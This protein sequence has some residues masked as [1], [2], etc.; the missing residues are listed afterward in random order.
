MVPS[1][2]LTELWKITIFNG[3]IHYKWQF[4]IAMLNYQRVT[5]RSKKKHSGFHQSSSP[6]VICFGVFVIPSSTSRSMRR[7]TLGAEAA[8]FVLS[9]VEAVPAVS[10]LEFQEA[11]EAAEGCGN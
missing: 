8:R 5:H 1:G 2:K 3:N 6:L 7:S 10:R 4:S 11:A 9:N